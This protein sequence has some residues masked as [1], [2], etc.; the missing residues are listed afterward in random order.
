MALNQVSGKRRP[1]KEPKP[2]TQQ[3][4]ARLPTEPRPFA[5][6]PPLQ[7]PTAA[8]QPL[9]LRGKV[10]LSVGEPFSIPFESPNGG[11]RV[12]YTYNVRPTSEGGSTPEVVTF[13][14]CNA[15]AAG[16]SEAT[17]TAVLH[18]ADST[19]CQGSG[20]ATLSIGGTMCLARWEASAHVLSLFSG[21]MST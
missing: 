10:S 3:S 12:R 16:D 9:I 14:L 8:A 21:L 4:H 1:S 20:E 13:M 17:G 5:E 19:G 18:M 6:E 11:C 2:V 15:S 7:E